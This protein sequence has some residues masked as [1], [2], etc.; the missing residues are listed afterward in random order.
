MLIKGV[1]I[2]EVLIRIEDD[3]EVLLGWE[4]EV[5]LVH[6]L[7][8]SIE[9]D[10]WSEALRRNKDSDESCHQKDRRDADPPL[11]DLFAL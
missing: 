7:L 6:R 2:V 9:V 11:E 8:G 10:D 5:R 4:Y 3:W 1:H